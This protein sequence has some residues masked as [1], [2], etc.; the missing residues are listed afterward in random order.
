MPKPTLV[1]ECLAMVAP[2]ETAFRSRWRLST[3]KRVN[4]DL[5]QM[6]CEQID[7]YDDALL[8]GSDADLKAQAEA[9]V[10]GWRAAC[11]ALEA[12]LQ[13]DDA[14]FVGQDWESGTRVVIS[15]CRQSVG[16]VQAIKDQAGNP[17]KVIMITPDEVARMVAGLNMIA[18]AK[19]VFPDAEVISIYPEYAA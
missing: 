13:A 9:M 12:P 2:A 10:R 19:S 5:H 8:R 4:P 7:L 6:L 11:S 17:G 1:A 16:R 18:A 14:Y 15:D 3:L